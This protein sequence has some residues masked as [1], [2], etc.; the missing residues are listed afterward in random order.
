MKGTIRRRGE[1]WTWQFQVADATREGGRRT[2]SKGGF[3]LRREA[4]AA[5]AE[6]LSGFQDVACAEP[7]KTAFIDYLRGDWLSSL[8]GL[9]PSTV[10]GY[11]DQVEPP[12]SDLS[13]YA[14]SPAPTCSA[15]TP[16]CEPTAGGGARVG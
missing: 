1:S 9:K 14:T 8:D 11:R 3:R 5:L 12:T 6:A 10:Q 15:S 2:I 4:E 7:A 13:A 16:N